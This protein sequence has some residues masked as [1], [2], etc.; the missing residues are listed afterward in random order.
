MCRRL[1]TPGG[2]AQLEV[3]PTCLHLQRV[4][5]A[6]NMRRFS[7]MTIQRDLFGGASLVRV[8]GRIGTRGRQ[9]VNTH[10]DEGKAITALMAL[11]E[12]KRCR[13]YGL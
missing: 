12:E 13:G 3:F 4:K 1:I 9:L 2:S 6:R 7:R 5:P 11:A 8:W 10:A